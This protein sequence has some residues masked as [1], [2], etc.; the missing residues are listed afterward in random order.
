MALSH[1]WGMNDHRTGLRQPPKPLMPP[2]P[3][4]LLPWVTPSTGR[5]P[6][7]RL[8]IKTARVCLAFFLTAPKGGG[9][10]QA[11]PRLPI[12]TRRKLR[13]K[14]SGRIIHSLWASLSSLMTL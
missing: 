4:L 6:L 12:S 14:N 7:P 1:L 8:G 5:H 9:E 13:T 10:R 3:F 2:C 11:S